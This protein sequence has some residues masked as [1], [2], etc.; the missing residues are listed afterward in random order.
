MEV[1][2]PKTLEDLRKSLE[3]LDALTQ[4]FLA[5]LRPDGTNWS[6]DAHVLFESRKLELFR[7]YLNVV[8]E[9]PKLVGEGWETN[10]T[11]N[12]EK[13]DF[14]NFDNFKGSFKMVRMTLALVDRILNPREAVTIGELRDRGVDFIADATG[15]QCRKVLGVTVG[16]ATNEPV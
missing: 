4:E 14:S 11:Q 2:S 10:L 7:A 15:A 3:A 13:I 8:E 16:D 12:L 6:P 9:T 5:F 1:V